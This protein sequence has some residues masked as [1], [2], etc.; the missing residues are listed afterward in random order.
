MIWSLPYSQSL[1]AWIHHRM[2]R[3][4]CGLTEANGLDVYTLVR[5][6]GSMRPYRYPRELLV[7]LQ[8]STSSLSAL[9]LEMYCRD[10]R[11]TSIS[12]LLISLIS[13]CPNSCSSTTFYG[14]CLF[15][16]FIYLFIVLINSVASL[17][18]AKLFLKRLSYQQKIIFKRI[19]MINALTFLLDFKC[20]FKKR[21]TNWT[22][23]NR[24]SRFLKINYWQFKTRFRDIKSII[25]GWF[26]LVFFSVC[27]R[28]K[29]E[30]FCHNRSRKE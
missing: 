20:I 8:S 24:Y 30:C 6:V 19:I 15:V 1:F 3:F 25:A 7:I 11:C 16:L 5:Q 12:T 14:R 21:R 18:F 22:K 10:L 17:Q 26:M 9:C 27:Y 4:L 29:V 28:R 13:G 2:K 23:C